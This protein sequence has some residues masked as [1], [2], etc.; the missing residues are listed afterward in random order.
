M[1]GINFGNSFYIFLF[2][3]FIFFSKVIEEFVRWT[4]TLVVY[5]F[6]VKY[7]QLRIRQFLHQ[8]ASVSSIP[9]NKSSV[10][11]FVCKKKKHFVLIIL[12]LVPIYQ[13]SRHEHTNFFPISR[14]VFFQKLL[15]VLF[16]VMGLVFTKV[17]Q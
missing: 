12:R 9:V 3:N 17:Y 1:E 16:L 7:L 13:I 14:K 5:H 10:E 6:H 15:Y 2:K 8:N 4:L 11:F